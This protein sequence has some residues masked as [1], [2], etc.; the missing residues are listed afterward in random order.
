MKTSDV[1]IKKRIAKLFILMV[2][3]IFFLTMRVGYIQFVRGDELQKKALDNRLREVTIKSKRGTI[4]DRNLKELA[5]SI[6]ADSVLAF[7]PQI[8]KSDKEEEIAKKLAEILEMDEKDILRKITQNSSSVWI[9]RKIQDFEKGKKLKDLNLVGVEVIED[10]Q[11][12]YPH[13]TLACHVLGF[14]GVDNQGL[15][16]I[17]IV[18]DEDLKG[19]PGRIVIE[20]DA[21]ER[22]LPQAMHRYIPPENGNNLVLTID[23]TIQY[24][25]ERELDQLMASETD[26][27]SAT[28][29]VMEPKT[30]EILALGSRPAYD[31]NNYNEYPQK[32]WRNI[33]VSNSYEPGSTFKIITAAAALEENVIGE[34]EKFHDPGFIKV[35]S[36]RIRCWAHV[37]HGVQTFEE[38]MQNSCNPALVTVG[39]KLK[40]KDRGLFYKYIR[41]F[42]FGKKTG[43]TLPGEADGLMILEEDLKDI[44][45]AT[46][47]IGQGIAVTPM[48]L[49]SAVSAS[50][51]GGRFMRPHLVKEVR[52]NENKLIKKFGNTE[53]RQVISEE[54]SKELCSLL[55]KVVVDGTGLPGYIEGYRVAAKTGTAQKAGAGGYMQ[56][57]YVASF[58]GFAPA[59]DP[60]LAILVVVD[61]PKGYPYYGG[62]VAGPI[63]KRIMED[64]LHYLGV[65]KQSAG[66]VPSEIPGEP[67][68]RKDV[69]V[70]AVDGMN[71]DDAK[72]KL[73]AAGLKSSVQGQGDMVLSQLP[74]TGAT[75]K[76]GTEIILY[77]GGGGE[78]ITIPNMSGK[79]IYEAVEILEALGLR[80]KTKGWGEAHRQIPEPGEKV[81]KGTEVEVWFQ[82][83]GE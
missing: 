12:F 15:E 49:I 20:H 4:Y 5:V 63:F 3:V 22:E 21:K 11:R 40:E 83:N 71:L 14:A 1:S 46:I 35:G 73:Y 29:I 78:E 66:E 28:I 13:D 74:K 30:F 62:T 48:Q 2:G 61:E 33:A 56:G 34:D 50:A 57:R 24:I 7:P 17:E 39:L 18:F 59:N 41:G 75:V 31:P 44:N 25:V 16:G 10:S 77:T 67:A 52:D 70:P 6:S 8:R 42:G 54:T 65:S 64:S 51:N 55:E 43:V 79:R 60:Q 36:E 9:K 58:V 81:K 32:T 38:A 45:I 72:Q 19:V 47:A 82:D 26:P 53:V 80:L 23:E 68:P 69:Q 37:P 27:E 76:E